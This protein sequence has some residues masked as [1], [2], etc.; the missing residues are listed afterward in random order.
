MEESSLGQ[1][2]RGFSSCQTGLPEV[3]LAGGGPGMEEE[4]AGMEEPGKPM[5]TRC[6]E[7]HLPQAPGE[8]AC[9]QQVLVCAYLPGD[10][11]VKGEKC[12]CPVAYPRGCRRQ[13]IQVA[14]SS[15]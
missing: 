8:A 1:A 14:P 11:N 15:R 5:W 4:E 3:L 6:Q 2:L 7:K 10:P 12:H 9:F 13:K